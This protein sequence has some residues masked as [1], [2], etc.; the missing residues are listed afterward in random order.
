MKLHDLTLAM[1]A[2]TLILVATQVGAQSPQNC[3]PRDVILE[4]L[5]QSYGESRQSIGLG[6]NNSLVEVFA[7]DDTGSWTITMTLANGMT[8][9]MAS[10]QAF[11]SLAEALPA[12]EK[13]A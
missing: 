3:G 8:C 11:E 7:S 1:A 4:R 10:G 13:D 12:A 9:L 5:A 6:G 2:S